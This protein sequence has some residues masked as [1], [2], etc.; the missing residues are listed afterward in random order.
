MNGGL[1]PEVVCMCTFKIYFQI[2]PPNM[3]ESTEWFMIFIFSDENL[4]C[5]SPLS[6]HTRTCPAHIIP[7]ATLTILAKKHKLQTAWYETFYSLNLTFSLSSSLISSAL[8]SPIA[9]VYVTF[10]YKNAILSNK[11]A[12]Q[13]TLHYA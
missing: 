2:S 4:V 10:C 5:N 8:S 3:P 6:I 13:A 11:S 1:A 9:S 7:P 12:M